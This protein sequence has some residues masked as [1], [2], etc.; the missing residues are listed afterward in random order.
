V[1]DVGSPVEFLTTS[2][3][4]IGPDR[5]VV[6]R[7]GVLINPLVSPQGPLLIARPAEMPFFA[8][9]IDSAWQAA[10]TPPLPF[11]ASAIADVLQSLHVPVRALFEH[12]ITD[13][14][15]EEV[16]RKETIV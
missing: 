1:P 14:L 7:T 15:R 2:R 12:S 3:F 4:L 9:D 13:K 16:L 6:L 10:V 5:N 11:N 8:I